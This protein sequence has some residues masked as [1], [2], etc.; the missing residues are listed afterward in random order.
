MKI[1]WRTASISI[2]LSDPEV[3]T[4]ARKARALLHVSVRV[5]L[6][7]VRLTARIK[8]ARRDEFTGPLSSCRDAA[9]AIQ[10]VRPGSRD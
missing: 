7:V 10:G 1:Y 5:R 2:K 8:K 6:D 9:G 4:Q 3:R